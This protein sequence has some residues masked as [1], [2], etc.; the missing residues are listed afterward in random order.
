MTFKT[1]TR[2][3]LCARHPWPQGI[4]QGGARIAAAGRLRQSEGQWRDRGHPEVLSRGGENPLELGRYETHDL[5]AVV[6]RI[7][8]KASA[9]TRISESIETAL[10]AGAGLVTVLEESSKGAWKEHRFS[11]HLACPDHPECSLSE[12]S[13]RLFSFNSPH[14]ACRDCDGLGTIMAFDEGLV[15]PEPTKGFGDGHWSHGRRTVGDSTP[16]T[17]VSSDAS[18]RQRASID[19]P[20]SRN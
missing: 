12:L 18:A 17:A 9:R 14:G 10:K 7:A 2:L 15:V 19:R 1:G 5:D 8:I 6:D 13:P 3:I 16:G 20:P 11:E 4:P